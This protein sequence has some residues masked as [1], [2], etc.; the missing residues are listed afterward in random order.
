MNH[1]RNQT[2]LLSAELKDGTCRPATVSRGRQY[3]VDSEW[4]ERIYL[5]TGVQF[6]EMAHRTNS[7][8][9]RITLFVLLYSH[10]GN[11]RITGTLKR[12]IGIISS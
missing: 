6:C 7:R 2:A 1:L 8:M 11:Y 5:V 4:N 10:Y 9:L 12:I 3:L